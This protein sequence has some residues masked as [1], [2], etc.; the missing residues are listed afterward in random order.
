MHAHPFF[1]KVT[2]TE[3]LSEHHLKRG[4]IATIIEFYHTLRSQ[5]DSYSL[6]G[7]EVPNITIKVAASKGMPVEQWQHEK[8]SCLSCTNS[9]K[10]AW[11]NGKT[12]PSPHSLFLPILLHHQLPQPPQNRHHLIHLIPLPKQRKQL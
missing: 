12:P 10:A 3:G 5:E 4:A 8:N 1:S 9:L 6:E 7:F 2:L 11:F